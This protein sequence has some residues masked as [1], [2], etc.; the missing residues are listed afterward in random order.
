MSQKAFFD[1]NEVEARII[2]IIEHEN[3]IIMHSGTQLSRKSHC[4]FHKQMSFML[5]LPR[6]VDTLMNRSK[7]VEPN[8]HKR[9]LGLERITLEIDFILEFRADKARK[10]P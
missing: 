8:F 7:N 5:F 6:L 1:R 3:F 4:T 10:V 9:R 2:S